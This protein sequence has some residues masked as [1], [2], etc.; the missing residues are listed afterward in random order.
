[1]SAD[2]AAPRDDRPAK[3]QLFRAIESGE[4][5]SIG[6][7]VCHA[8]PHDRPY[9]ERHD[10]F[11][12]A[13]VV[14]G[15]FGYRSDGGRALM[16]PGAFVLGRPG[17]CYECGH[18]HGVGDRCII[19]HFSQGLFEQIAATATGSHRFRFPVASL[20]TMARTARHIVELEAFAAGGR[21][22]AGEE[23][24]L[25]LAGSAIAIAAGE[26]SA[27]ASPSASEERR[28]GGVL[29]HIENNLAERLDLAALAG[30]AAMSKF[31]FLRT[32][33]RIVGVT[34]YRYLL[35]LRLRRAALRICATDE[36]VSR[37]AYD[38]GFGDLSTFNAQFRASY[39]MPPGMLRRH[40]PRKAGRS[41]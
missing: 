20:P 25:W 1:M 16:Q 24:A 4:G 34:P 37:I 39:G 10:A 11:S 29:R 36:P 2:P 41:A 38:T 27:R 28:I 30:L 7:H 35:E 32:F 8:G 31:H 17:A 3:L 19:V 14:S 15:S 23:L 13:A 21:R 9:E 18:E 33:R 5:W 26:D 12:V 6:E 22:L 40:G